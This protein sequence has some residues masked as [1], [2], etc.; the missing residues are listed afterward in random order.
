MSGTRFDWR[1]FWCPPEGAWALDGDGFLVDP[2]D[3][4]PYQPPQPD[5]IA[6]EQLAAVGCVAMLGELGSGKSDD[7]RVACA[8]SR[9]DSRDGYTAELVDLRSVD[10]ST[11]LQRLVFDQPWFKQWVGDDCVLEL[12]LDSADEALLRVDNLF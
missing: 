9:A 12:F 3:E 6:F 8:A 11:R 2:E 10:S 5:V 1:R 7:L 4:S